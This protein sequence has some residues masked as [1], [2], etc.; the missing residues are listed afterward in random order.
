M[1]QIASIFCS[2][3]S[4]I[5]LFGSRAR[6]DADNISDADV[7]IVSQLPHL[8]ESHDE[9][10]K[11]SL[12][13]REEF[14]DQ[15]SLGHYS[16]E[17]IRKMYHDGDLFAWH[18]H[19]ESLKIGYKCDDFLD[20]LV[21]ADYANAIQDLETFLSIAAGVHDSLSAAPGNACYEAGLL[22]MVSRNIAM[23]ASW[24]VPGGPF[25]GRDS[26]FR[27]Q[28]AL[29][30]RFPLTVSEHDENMKARVFGHRGLHVGSR[31]AS[32]VANM[33]NAV[34]EW[35]VMVLHYA[36]EVESAGC[37]RP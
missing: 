8:G 37:S 19:K 14:G 28:G 21:P 23:S 36:K 27:L 10:A 31:A 16:E 30:I 26:P 33:A 18:I 24:Y 32:H 22:F 34:L 13:L 35:G 7:L 11:A 4:A 17:R 12:R 9:V 20:A 3:Y 2:S 5:R 29:G 1:T 6:G 15:L 25:F